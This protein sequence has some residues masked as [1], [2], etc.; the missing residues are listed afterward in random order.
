MS[1]STLEQTLTAINRRLGNN[2]IMYLRDASHFQVQKFSTGH[3]NLDLALGGG[4]PKG[5]IIEIFGSEGCGKTTLALQIITEVQKFGYAAFIDVDHSLDPDYAQILGVNVNN[6]LVS[7]PN[8]AETALTI[9]EKL[10]RSQVVN[11]IIVDSV[12]ALITQSELTSPIH[13]QSSNATAT[14]MSKALRR[15]TTCMHNNCILIFINQLRYK[16]GTCSDNVEVSPGGY[17]LK[18][19]A[20]IRLDM[21]TTQVLRKGNED[22][23]IRSQIKVVKNKVARPLKM[24][25]VDILFPIGRNFPQLPTQLVKNKVAPALKIA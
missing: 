14:L 6:L 9:V 17:A 16:S 23:G 4:I 8:N 10:V 15:I 12:A 7:R 11:L 24:A 20:S 2:S 22:Y 18:C 19:Y 21:R 1:K 25:E 3:D 13:E 5:R